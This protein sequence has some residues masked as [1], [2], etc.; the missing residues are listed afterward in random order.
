[1]VLNNDAPANRYPGADID[2]GHAGQILI[3]LNRLE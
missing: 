3:R 2:D 1:M